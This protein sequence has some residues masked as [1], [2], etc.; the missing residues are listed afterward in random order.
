VRQFGPGHWMQTGAD[1]GLGIAARSRRQMGDGVRVDLPPPARG[2]LEQREMP[3]VGGSGRRAVK[4]GGEHVVPGQLAVEASG[5]FV[6][7][8]R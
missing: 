7:V 2:Q 5:I 8:D 1:C 6:Q 3:A 4:V